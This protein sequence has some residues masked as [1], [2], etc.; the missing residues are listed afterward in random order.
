MND[1]LLDSYFKERFNTKLSPE[2]EKQFIQWAKEQKKDPDMETIDY[3]LRGF[4]KDG[5]SFADNG[6]GSDYYKKPNHPTFST[7]SQYH[8][9]DNDL[10]G[11][12]WEGGTWTGN[13]YRPSL[14]MMTTTHDRV[15]LKNYWKDAK[16]P[17]KLFLR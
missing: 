4:F 3:D 14:K 1:A 15:A 10:F 13:D 7:E 6:H 17:G 12:K 8:G 9:T 2:E 11:G 16:E 5:K